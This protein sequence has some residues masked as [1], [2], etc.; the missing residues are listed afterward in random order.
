M[1]ALRYLL[2][3]LLFLPFLAVA[4]DAWLVKDGT[5]AAR[6][7]ISDQP[8]RMVRLAAEELRDYLR[9][10]SGAELPIATE[11][12]DNLVS[13]YVG[14][15][16]HTDRL[17]LVGHDLPDGAYRMVTGENWLALLG[18]DSDF[19]PPQ[20]YKTTYSDDARVLA[21]WDALTGEKWLFPHTLLF[22]KC[23][24]ELGIWTY[25]ERGSLNA[26]HGFLHRL[27][28]RW[29]M[30]GELGE[31]VPQQ[32]TIPLPV[33]DETVRP[34]FP[35][36][37]FG[38]YAPVWIG[39][40]A[41]SILWHLRLGFSPGRD[42]LGLSASCWLGHGICLIHGRDEAKRDHPEYFALYNGRR[43][44]G[45]KHSRYGK[46]CL[47][48][49]ELF[50]ANVRFI[51]AF[52]QVYP[53]EPMIGVMPADA[54]TRLC[55]CPLCQGKDDPE[56]GPQGHLSDYVWDY[57]NRVA[58]EVRT[59]HPDKKIVCFAYGSYLLPP[60]KIGKLSPN[61]AVG[62][63]QHRAQFIDPAVEQLYLE[64]RQGWLDKLT[65]GDFYLWEYYLYSRPGHTYEGIPVYFPQAI[66]RDLKR[67]RSVA[68]GEMVEQTRA[69]GT[70]MHAPIFNHLNTYVTS[71][72]YWDANLDVDALL[73]EYYR[74]FYGP[75]AGPMQAF[76]E[77][78]EQHWPEMLTDPAPIDRAL[79]LFAAARD[80]VGATTV[81]G[82]RLA[83]LAEFLVPLGQLRDR[84]RKGRTD[85]PSCR[86][87]LSDPRSFKLD[88]QL[89]EPFWEASSPYPLRETGTGRAPYFPTRFR[90]AWGKDAL[91]VGIHCQDLPGYRPHVGDAVEILI[92]TQTHAYYRITVQ[93]DGTLSAADHAQF[94]NPQWQ[95]GAEASVHSG[96]DHWTVE[97]RLPLAKTGSPDGIAGRRPSDTYPWFINVCRQ[98]LRPNGDERSAF[99]PTGRPE[100]PEPGK[101]AR[102]VSPPQ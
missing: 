79:A 65:S 25:D 100:F 34:D 1:T 86:V 94:P 64:A 39:D 3:P 51:R 60:K 73:G 58:E 13:V 89:D 38:P 97:L 88:G 80:A 72:F 69:A 66:A 29:Y 10:I 98:R 12:D 55:E 76:V 90:L 22:K 96:E 32:T 36:R 44:T 84:L 57:V 9:K 8:P 27:G 102:L 26:V 54:Y 62:F 87:L 23:S 83:L 33:L 93:A 85:A 48:S 14:R 49:P 53:D 2:L 16:V 46:P 95:A 56:R 28:V 82:Q 71:R 67:L 24:K 30:Q 70:G 81:P 7:V 75:A 43:F 20:P 42:Q 19:T 4:G 78:C 35:V 47:S 45:D 6:I 91:H 61:L 52:F 31:V 50:A 74:D 41:E 92:E 77:F 68:R 40:P 21:E 63:C 59:T 18:R 101:F 99:S 11:P 15:S 5:P 37:D 17:G